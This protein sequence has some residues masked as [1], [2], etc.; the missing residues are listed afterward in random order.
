LSD[1]SKSEEKEEKEKEKDDDDGHGDASLTFEDGDWHDTGFVLLLEI[2]KN[3]RPGHFYV[4]CNLTYVDLDDRPQVLDVNHRSFDDRLL[5]FCGQPLS[6]TVAKVDGRA[7]FLSSSASASSPSSPPTS[8][9]L[10]VPT[11]RPTLFEEI[12]LTPMSRSR[13]EIVE[14]GMKGSWMGC[15]DPPIALYPP[16]QPD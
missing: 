9:F 4:V 1:K 12:Q 11:E 14:T 3:G 5:K 6:F 13:P 10:I 7:Q 16:I 8:S 2:S 15:G